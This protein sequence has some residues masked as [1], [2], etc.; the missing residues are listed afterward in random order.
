MNFVNSEEYNKMKRLFIDRYLYVWII[1]DLAICFMLCIFAPIDIFY[2]NRDEY[3][4][5][6]GQMFPSIAGV[7]LYLFISSFVTS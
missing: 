3:W 6:L 4:F 7:F 5:T 1:L 2:A